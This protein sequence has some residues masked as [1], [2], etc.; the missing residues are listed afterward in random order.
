MSVMIVHVTWGAH[1]GKERSHKKTKDVCSHVSVTD[2]FNILPLP[3]DR[4]CVTPAAPTITICW[5]SSAEAATA[6][7]CK[8]ST[9]QE[10]HGEPHLKHDKFSKLTEEKYPFKQYLPA[11]N[12]F[13]H[14]KTSWEAVMSFTHLRVNEYMNCNCFFISTLYF[15]RIVPF[16]LTQ[17]PAHNKGFKLWQML[18]W[19]RFT[20]WSK[21]ESEKPRK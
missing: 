8:Q 6:R 2:T 15:L 21:T 12:I 20:S 10:I 3:S 18:K 7:A 19:T 5:D 13:I 14:L 4:T 9:H 16:N 11:P 1:S 17:Y